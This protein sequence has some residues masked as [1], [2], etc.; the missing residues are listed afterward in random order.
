MLVYGGLTADRPVETTLTAAA[1]NFPSPDRLYVHRPT[2][3]ETVLA[4]LK[5]N[6]LPTLDGPWHYI[7]PFDSKL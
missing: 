6:R 2:W 1:P 3:T 7:G 4:T 5:A